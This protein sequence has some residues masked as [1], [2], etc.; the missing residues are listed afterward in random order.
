[1]ILC[2]KVIHYTLLLLAVSVTKYLFIF[3]VKSAAGSNDGFW[4]VF[5]NALIFLVARDQSYKA[6]LSVIHEF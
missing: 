1:M 3:V 2:P 4:L 6:F 5:I